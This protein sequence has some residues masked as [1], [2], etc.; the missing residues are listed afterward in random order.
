[1]N[2]DVTAVQY[3]KL[4]RRNLVS[5]LITG[6]EGETS[7]GVR[8]IFHPVNCW[9]QRPVIAERLGVRDSVKGTGIY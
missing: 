4:T 9:Q 5:D 1:M 7:I 3:I 6:N 8:P 2:C